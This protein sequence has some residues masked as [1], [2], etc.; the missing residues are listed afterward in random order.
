SP[1][2]SAA[3]RE[4]VIN[5]RPEISRA[6]DPFPP[7]PEPEQLVIP[8]EPE[9][10]EPDLP[11][12]VAE[13]AP[14]PEPEA[15]VEVEAEVTQP[16]RKLSAANGAPKTPVRPRRKTQEIGELPDDYVYPKRY[17]LPP[18]D[19]FEEGDYSVP[20]DLTEQLHETS[21][22]LEETLQ[23]FSIEAR[24]TDVTRGPTITRYELEPAP[25][26]KVSRFLSLADDLALALKAH[27]VRVEA[28]IPGK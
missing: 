21:A 13:E 2:K 11:E 8:T 23:T 18:L 25:G 14:A 17:T 22:V 12:E 27:R 20:Q 6:D 24:V 10:L 1:E 15:P 16:A 7:V 3:P 5:I 9:E 26:I 28:P 19:L 4:R